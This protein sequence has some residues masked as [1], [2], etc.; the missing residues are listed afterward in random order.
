MPFKPEDGAF[1]TIEDL[2]TAGVAHKITVRNWIKSGKLRA[3]R[4]GRNYQIRGEDLREY[5]AT[6]KNDGTWTQKE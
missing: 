3:T 6:G 1:Y 2:V 5:F 4:I